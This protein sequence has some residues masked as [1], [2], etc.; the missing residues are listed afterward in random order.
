M[1]IMKK[2]ITILFLIVAVTIGYSQNKISADLFCESIGG[3]IKS[4][5]VVVSNK[6]EFFVTIILIPDYIG[7]NQ[8]ALLLDNYIHYKTTVTRQEVRV[9]SVD[10]NKVYVIHLF[11]KGFLI[12]ILYDPFNQQ[13]SLIIPKNYEKANISFISTVIFVL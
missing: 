3:E 1:K 10:G 2:L 7:V 4:S 9:Y 5:S 13:V 11:D 6:E 12:K 8:F